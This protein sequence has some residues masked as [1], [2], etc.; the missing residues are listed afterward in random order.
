MADER[1]EL[2]LLLGSLLLRWL[3]IARGWL[4]H[5]RRATA[6]LVL[7]ATLT[8]CCGQLVEGEV[9]AEAALLGG[10]AFLLIANAIDHRLHCS[11]ARCETAGAEE[12]A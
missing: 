5:R 7:A 4:V 11:G 12:P 8:L 6:Y 3:V 10:T 2:A 9:A 1:L